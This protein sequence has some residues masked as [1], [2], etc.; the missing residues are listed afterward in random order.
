MCGWPLAGA[1]RNKES[2]RGSPERRYVPVARKCHGASASSTLNTALAR[3]FD[4]RTRTWHSHA[5]SHCWRRALQRQRARQLPSARRRPH[6]GV[7]ASKEQGKA[8]AGRLRLSGPMRAGP[9]AGRAES[10][11]TT[12]QRNRSRPNCPPSV[13]PRT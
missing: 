5:H 1:G 2:P 3:A 10:R 13:A 4:T 9:V 7:R 11:A 12:C 6:G 8:E